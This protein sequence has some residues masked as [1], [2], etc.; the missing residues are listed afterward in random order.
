M[1]TYRKIQITSTLF[2]G[3]SLWINVAEYKNN[4]D[5]INIIRIRLFNL[6]QTFNLITLSI[7]ASNLQLT[8]PIYR[9]CDDM[10]KKTSCKDIIHIH[11]LK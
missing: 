1:D 9:D 7:Y 6:L 8:I 4:D 3:Y 2:Q 11:E 5:I 10:L